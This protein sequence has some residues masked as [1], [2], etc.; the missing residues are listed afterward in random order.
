MKKLFAF[1][2]LAA[3][4]TACNDSADSK[5]TTDSTS[6]NTTTVTNEADSIKRAADSLTTPDSLR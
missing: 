4:M 2:A 5:K 3:I 6:V 1:I